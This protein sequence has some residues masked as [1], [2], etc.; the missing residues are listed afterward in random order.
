MPFKEKKLVND[1]GKSE[2]LGT[3]AFQ[4]CMDLILAGYR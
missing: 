2:L 4:Q 3:Y 1:K